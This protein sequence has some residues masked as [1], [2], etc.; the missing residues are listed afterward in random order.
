MQVCKPGM[1]MCIIEPVQSEVPYEKIERTLIPTHHTVSTNQVE[2]FLRS[3]YMYY[4][5]DYTDSLDNNG[6]SH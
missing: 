2:V 5:N 6:N 4:Y 1:Y 3:S